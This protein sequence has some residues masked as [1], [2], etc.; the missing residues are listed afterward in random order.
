MAHPKVL[1]STQYAILTLQTLTT[2][3]FLESLRHVTSY[4][5]MVAVDVSTGAHVLLNH[6]LSSLSNSSELALATYWM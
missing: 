2:A 3:S 5:T 4:R 6:V 1:L